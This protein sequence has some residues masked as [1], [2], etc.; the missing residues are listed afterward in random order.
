MP[1]TAWNYWN[2]IQFREHVHARRHAPMA[3]AQGPVHAL[4]RPRLPGRL[5][6]RQRH[7]AISERHRRF[8]A[9]LLHRLPVLRHR[10]PLQHPQVQSAN[11]EDVQVHALQRPRLARSGARVHQSLSHRLPA[12][13]HQ[14]RHVRA[15]RNAR[16]TTARAHLAHQGRSLRSPG[17]RRR[18]RH[19]RAARHHQS[20]SLRRTAQESARAARRAPVEGSAQMARQPGHDRR[21]H[22]RDPA[23]S[24]LRPQ[25]GEA[26]SDLPLHAARTRHTLARRA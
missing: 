11:Q 2:L 15:G 18:Q 23:L 8:P 12:L 4:R 17:C 9:G 25:A 20:R 26:T 13:R 24:P 5:P 16:R 14:G 10:L 7:R 1:E 21:P 3:H 6:R 19:L 22:R